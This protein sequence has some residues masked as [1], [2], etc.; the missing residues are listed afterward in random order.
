MFKILSN[1]ASIIFHPLAM[2]TI[3]YMIILMVFP[4]EETLINPNAIIYVLIL[5]AITTGIVPAIAIY[6]LYT[7]GLISSINLEKRADRL[8]PNLISITL[9]G[10]TS[11]LFY[12]KLG[13]RGVM[14]YAIVCFTATLFIITIITLIWKISVH[15]C[16]MGGVV[17]FL[18]SIMYVSQKTQALLVP[19]CLSTIFL[20]LLMSAR[21]YLGCHTS[22]QVWAG[23]LLGI[24]SGFVTI[25]FITT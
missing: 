3:I 18:F 16:A 10:I 19:S 11:F 4:Y 20:G 15:A 8:L 7:F 17:G 2:P 13:F 23:A 25:F 22:K 21:M 1:I 5:V 24:I 12:S 14:I 6:I 9:Y